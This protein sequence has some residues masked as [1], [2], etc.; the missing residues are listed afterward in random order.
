MQLTETESIATP[1]PPPR[2]SVFHHE[3]VGLCLGKPSILDAN[4]ATSLE[5]AS[6][7]PA[8]RVCRL[9]IQNTIKSSELRHLAQACAA[10]PLAKLPLRPT[11]EQ[12]AHQGPCTR[13]SDTPLRLLLAKWCVRVPHR[14]TWPDLVTCC[15]AYVAAPPWRKKAVGARRA[16]S[17]FLLGTSCINGDSA[18]QDSPP[19]ILAENSAKSFFSLRGNDLRANVPMLARFRS[20]LRLKSPPASQ[21][22]KRPLGT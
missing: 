13:R 11:V 16:T 12:S 9:V 15:V 10:V 14:C 20:V 4:V 17:N 8:V 1:S 2:H 3:G 18:T 19:D 21:P 6:C 7:V 22:P 5:H